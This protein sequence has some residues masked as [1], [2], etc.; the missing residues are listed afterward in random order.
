MLGEVHPDTLN[1]WDG[2]GR[3]QLRERKYVEAESTL[4]NVLKG[5][6]KVMPE[7]WERYNCQSM[8]GGSLE[9][10]KKY[11]EA[12]PLLISGYG[13]LMQREAAIP[14]ENR[15]VLSE[16]GQRIIQLYENWEKPGKAAKWRERL[17]P[18]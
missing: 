10:R 6:E 18:K 17:Q 4:R 5:Y 13:G 12:E 3:L 14:L 11:A 7:S 8:L 1:S 9:G 16:A 15:R 2:L